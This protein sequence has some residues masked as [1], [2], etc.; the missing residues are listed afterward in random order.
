MASLANGQFST[1]IVYF[2]VHHSGGSV[3]PLFAASQDDA[4]SRFV[5][6]VRGHAR[7]DF[8]L[9]R[10]RVTDTGDQPDS[11]SQ[12]LRWDFGRDPSGS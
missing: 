5:L 8:H 3:P 9:N 1:Y 4:S 6:A 7:Q 10:N 12:R 2:A 11:V